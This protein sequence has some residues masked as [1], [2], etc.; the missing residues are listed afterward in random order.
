VVAAVAWL[1]QQP[2]VDPQRIVMSGASFGGIQ[3]I[4]T[5]ENGLGIRAFVPFAPAAMS[6][7]NTELQD[8]LLEAEK[9]ATVPIFLI[10]AEGD[11]STGPYE[12]LGRYLQQKGGLNGA[13]L[14]PRFGTTSQEAH[15]A[16]STRAEG[17]KLWGPEVL[18]FFDKAMK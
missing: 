16:F 10:Q 4:L 7:R 15:G 2:Y 11:Y 1:K 5:D 3:T 18:R 14:Y 9:K 17:I 13:K 8:R 12:K 6:W